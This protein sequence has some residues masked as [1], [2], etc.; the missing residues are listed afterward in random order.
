MSLFFFANIFR[1]NNNWV[2]LFR[3]TANKTCKSCLAPRW[4]L[5]SNFKSTKG[6][7][8]WKVIFQQN[9]RETRRE[10]PGRKTLCK[11]MITKIVEKFRNTGSVENDDRGHSGRYVTVKTRANLQAVKKHLNNCHEN[12]HDYC[13]KKSTFQEQLCKESFTMT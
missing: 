11:K 13:L 6:R 12:W 7:K 3:D 1:E 5:Q 10:F 9:Q 2:F 4:M 8:F